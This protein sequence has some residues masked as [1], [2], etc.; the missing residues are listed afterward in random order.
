MRNIRVAL[1]GSGF[2]FPALVG[3]LMAIRDSGY[4]V[5]EL[6]GTSGGSIVAALAACGMNLEDMKTMT[7]NRNWSEML[8]ADPFSWFKGASS[9]YCSGNNLLKWISEETYGASFADLRIPLTIMSSDAST[10]LPF[11]FSKNSTP[12]TK[13]A[14]AARCSACIPVVYSAVKFQ[15]ALLQDGGLVNN[16]PVDK[17]VKDDVLRLGVQLVSKTAP[18]TSGRHSIGELLSRDL[19]MILSANENTHVEMDEYE[20]AKFAFIETGYANGLDRNMSIK[21]RTRLYNDAYASTLH[22]LT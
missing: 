15:G 20:G 4:N 11:E 9:G 17:L 5:I 22:A 12:N 7:L 6:A 3:A 19:N 16:I 14:F 2:K 10:E 13:V 8:T 18:L 21:I 1:S